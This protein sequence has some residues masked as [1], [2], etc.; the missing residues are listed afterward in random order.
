MN[1]G[2]DVSVED[3]KFSPQLEELVNAAISAGILKERAQAGVGFKVRDDALSFYSTRVARE[4]SNVDPRILKTAIHDVV[5]SALRDGEFKFYLAL[6]KLLD[7]DTFTRARD[8]Y[9]ARLNEESG[10]RFYTKMLERNIFSTEVS[11]GDFYPDGRTA[12][13]LNLKDLR[14]K[15][16]KARDLVED[17][18]TLL[19]AVRKRDLVTA[20]DLMAGRDLEAPDKSLIQTY[21]GL[22]AVDAELGVYRGTA[23]LDLLQVRVLLRS[24]LLSPFIDLGIERMGLGKAYAIVAM[25]E[26]YSAQEAESTVRPR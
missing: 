21:Q 3:F 6:S 5:E 23:N 11:E 15:L 8:H 12:E 16:I 10:I 17:A 13:G 4:Y 2:I 26:L 25:H 22:N 1:E 7:K 24:N 19:L 9:S 20:R 14:D 18:N